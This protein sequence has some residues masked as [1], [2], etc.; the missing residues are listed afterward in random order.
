MVELKCLYKCAM[1]VYSDLKEKIM[2]EALIQTYTYK[3]ELHAHSYPVSL[4]SEISPKEMAKLFIDNGYS[5]IVLTNHFYLGYR[6]EFESDAAYVEFYYNAY[7]ELLEAAGDKLKVCL[8]MEIRFENETMNDYL[9]YGIDKSDLGKACYYLDKDIETFYKGFKNERNVILQAHPFRDGMKEINMDYIDGIEVFNMHIHHNSRISK[10][11]Q[12]AK[13]LNKLK[14]CGTDLHYP[15]QI[16]TSY[17]RTK[18]LPENSFD[19]SKLIKSQD[20]ILQI[21]D[22]IVIP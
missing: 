19:L 9:V 6:N 12:C 22:I 11:A 2:K 13:E 21:S 17:V 20:M 4:C 8:G 10:A 14:L 16:G 7:A 15:Y 18:C 5:A 1:P 3:C